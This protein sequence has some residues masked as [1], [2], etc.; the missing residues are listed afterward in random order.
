MQHQGFSIMALEKKEKINSH[1]KSAD[2]SRSSNLKY[3]K[4]CQYT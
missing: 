2:L 3:P 4:Y 1:T